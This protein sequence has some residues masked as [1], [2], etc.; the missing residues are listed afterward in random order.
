MRKNEEKNKYS[1]FL[2]FLILS[3][4]IGV[5]VVLMLILNGLNK[6]TEEVESLSSTTDTM[7]I[8][9]S[10]DDSEMGSGVVYTPPQEDDEDNDSESDDE[11]EE[12]EDE[13][14][15]EPEADITAEKLFKAFKDDQESASSEYKN[16]KLTVSGSVLTI[17]ETDSEK[18]RIKL[19]A[20]EGTLACLSRKSAENTVEKVKEELGNKDEVVIEGLVDG[21]FEDEVELEDCNIIF[22]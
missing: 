16:E 13:E 6:I 11:E 21:F 4:N 18:V 14:E 12:N 20:D 1:E 3:F 9:V 10:E 7:E 17:D 15:D 8:E 19:E 2:L 22:D 5:F